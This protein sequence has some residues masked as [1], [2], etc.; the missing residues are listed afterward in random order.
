MPLGPVRLVTVPKRASKARV[1]EWFRS[2]VRP[3][4]KRP[5]A[6]KPL[7]VLREVMPLPLTVS[8]RRLPKSSWV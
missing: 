6:E 4:A 3:V 5:S 8:V 2:L 1:S 7:V